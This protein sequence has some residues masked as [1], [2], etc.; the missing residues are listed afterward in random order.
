[1]GRHR[2]AGP[3]VGRRRRDD[4]PRRATRPDLDEAPEPIHPT[5]TTPTP[6]SARP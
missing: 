1:M 2:A 3:A 4:G 5:E 6:R